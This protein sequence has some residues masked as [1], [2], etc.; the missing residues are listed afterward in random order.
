MAIVNERLAQA[1]VRD[2]TVLGRFD[3]DIL[4]EH[5]FVVS[6]SVKPSRLAEEFLR[7]LSPAQEPAGDSLGGD[8]GP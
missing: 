4:H 6:S 7:M 2:Q 3:P 8:F 1:Y 5:A